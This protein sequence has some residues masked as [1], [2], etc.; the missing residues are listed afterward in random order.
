MVVSMLP[1]YPVL[2]IQRCEF[3]IKQHQSTA[4]R[5]SCS[6][7][8][9]LRVITATL[10]SLCPANGQNEQP[11]WHIQVRAYAEAREWHSAMSVIEEQIARDPGDL[12]A[13]AWR[14]RVL[15][16]S[17]HLAEAENEYL[18][19]LKASPQDPDNWM[20]LGDVYF[21]EGKIQE[22]NRVIERAEKLDPNREDVHLARAR[23]LRAAGDR[24]EA[25]LEFLT[26]LRI[27]PQSVEAQTGLISVR[28][29]SKNE[30][31][32]GEDNDL[33]NF[34]GAN[35]LEW[36]SLTSKWTRNWTT[37]FSGDFYQRGGAD[38]EKLLGG[39]TRRQPKWGAVTV[40]G[41]IGHDNA[42]I[43][44]REVF[45]D[46]DH[47]FKTGEANFVSAIEIIYGQ[48]WYWYQASAILALNTT[49]II[50][51]P[52]EWTLSIGITNARSA[53]S[54]TAAE[55]RPSGNSR[56]RFPLAHWSEKRLAGDIFFATGTEDFAQ[57]DQIGRFASQTYGGGLQFTVNSRQDISGYGAYQKRTQNRTDT[58]FG[59]SYGIHF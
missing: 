51:L 49:A 47:G 59:L 10:L 18:E 24:N 42:V 21:R 36:T 41:A 43:P 44:K 17:S 23:A 15:T 35:H 33:F 3:K 28:N 52:R 9:L 6:T 38:A 2:N 30:L 19:I 22:A 11:D 46:L 37:S 20:G 32:F 12:D 57:V 54:G 14:A 26:A 56:I 4:D 8:I 45:F 16:W 13:R 40:G 48:H 53:F 7:L 25:R 27:N 50:Y 5:I 29:E 31:R 1:V 39:V 55:W 34:A 58:S